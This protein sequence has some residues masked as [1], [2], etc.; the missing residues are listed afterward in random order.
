[1]PRCFVYYYYGRL[2]YFFSCANAIPL[3]I[4]EACEVD[5][6]YSLC[7]YCDYPNCNHNYFANYRAI[8]HYRF[9]CYDFN[10]DYINCNVFYQYV[11]VMG[12]V[13]FDVEG[14]EGCLGE[15]MY[16]DWYQLTRLEHLRVCYNDQKCNAGN[17]GELCVCNVIF[18][19]LIY[20]QIFSQ[21]FTTSA[22]KRLNGF[23]IH[24]VNALCRGH[25]V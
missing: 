3:A 14:A 6:F 24:L 18:Q 25:G 11:P 4:R 23:V 17:L 2:Q 13:F 10:H 7:R 12:C 1:M 5:T 21:I 15:L 20:S 22:T 9:V 8:P 19:M 16:V